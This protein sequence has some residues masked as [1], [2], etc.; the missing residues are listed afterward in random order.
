MT[1]DD[2]VMQLWEKRNA[3]CDN[4]DVHY[5]L[6]A[7]VELHFVVQTGKKNRGKGGLRQRCTEC[8]FAYPCPTIEAVEK[9]LLIAKL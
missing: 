9:E 8:G 7:V 4:L 3:L 6:S 1:R 5:A 2:L